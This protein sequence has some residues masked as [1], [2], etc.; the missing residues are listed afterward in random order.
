[1]CFVTDK[2]GL[3]KMGV[4]VGRVMHTALV[5]FTILAP[6]QIP[7]CSSL[8][9]MLIDFRTIKLLSAY[10][11]PS[12]CA[13]LFPTDQFRPSSWVRVGGATTTATTTTLVYH[14]TAI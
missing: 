1:M 7:N 9:D 12:A 11:E 13:V 8:T 4:E 6:F 2:V 14:R 10:L 3:I 5:Y